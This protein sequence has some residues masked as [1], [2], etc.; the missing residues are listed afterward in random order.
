MR[1]TFQKLGP[2]LWRYRRGLFL[3]MGALIIKDLAAAIQPLLFGSGID[4]LTRGFAMSKVFWF[5][6]FLVGLSAFKGLFQY[7]MRVI[8]IGISRDIEFDLRNDL[9]VTSSRC[10]AISTAVTAPATSWR[11]LRTI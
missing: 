10:L 1:R 2:Y 3:G 6:A 7:W 8:L 9:F 11:A 4:S 5:A